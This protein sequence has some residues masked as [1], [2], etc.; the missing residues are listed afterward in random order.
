MRNAGWVE[1]QTVAHAW[2]C[3]S[4]WHSSSLHVFCGAL[5]IQQRCRSRTPF[6]EVSQPGGTST[7]RVS[8]R[9]SSYSSRPCIG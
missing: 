8:W 4:C 3:S 2:V 9:L 7:E 6:F 1:Q 5:A